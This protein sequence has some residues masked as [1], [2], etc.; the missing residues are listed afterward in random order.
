MDWEGAMPLRDGC[1]SGG[2]LLGGAEE[3]KGNFGDDGAGLPTDALGA[4]GSDADGDGVAA[5]AFW[6]Q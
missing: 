1:G 3:S 4:L 6:V 2:T 5:F